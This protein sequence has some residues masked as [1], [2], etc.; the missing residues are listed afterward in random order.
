MKSNK[1]IICITAIVS[2]AITSTF[3]IAFNHYYP[4][5]DISIDYFLA[6]R[7]NL[8][9]IDY[10]PVIYPSDEY[11]PFTKKQKELF[12]QGGI[13][14]FLERM[15]IKGYEV[16]S[17]YVGYPW[18]NPISLNTVLFNEESKNFFSHRAGVIKN[19]DNTYSYGSDPIR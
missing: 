10:A 17:I 19:D 7:S 12:Y 13:K 6:D 9:Y 8:P 14:P 18:E 2:I 1:K 3:F 11:Q 15:Q 4:D 5:K 16:V